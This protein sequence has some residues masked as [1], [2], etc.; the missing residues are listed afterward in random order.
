ME[1]GVLNRKPLLNRMVLV[2][3]IASL[4][5]LIG[6]EGRASA[7]SPGPRPAPTNPV[8]TIATIS[9]N[10]A[11]AGGAPFNLTI[12]GTNFVSSSAV[13]FG[14]TAPSTKFVSATQMTAAIPAD[15]ISSAGSI[16][17][18]VTS[19][20]PGGGTS[21]S[22]NFTVTSG[23]NP[24]PAISVLEPGG[25]LG[26]GPGLNLR[27]SGAN[28][29]ASSVVRWNGN[30]LPTTV[31]DS[32][33]A[34]AQIPASDV[35]ANGVASV[36]VVSPAP[37]GGS[38]SP[39]PF[40]IDG[41]ESPQSIAVDA[42]GKFVYVADGSGDV[43]EYSVDATT[44]ILTPIGRIAAGLSPR[45]IAIDPSGKFVYVADFGDNGDG[46]DV[47][48]ISM[49]SI[50]PSSGA[51]TSIGTIS[52]VPVGGGLLGCPDLCAPTSVDVDPSGKFLYVAN[53]GGPAPT[54]I[55]RWTVN[56]TGFLTF[57]G[58]FAGGGR[59]ISLAID[60]K[61]KF[62][63]AT[64]DS[65]SFPGE[66]NDVSMFTVN[67]TT[68]ALTFTGTIAAGTEPVSVAVDPSGKFVY[69]ANSASNDISVYTINVTTGAL[70]S[71]GT[72]AAGTRPISVAV[73]PTGKF[74]YVA[75]SDSNDISIYA[76]DGTTGALMSV[77]TVAT[78]LSPAAIAIHPSGKF[79]YVANSGSNSIS[80]Y[81][82]DATTGALTL[83]GTTG[84]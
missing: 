36:T 69:A 80:M 10:G 2:S 21:N 31:V 27:V 53:E 13:S 29:V 34:E 59:A 57:Q 25:A 70:T 50:S 79:V 26:G 61:G 5:L 78:E 43:S 7:P 49:Y 17:V 76:I 55:P 37:G 20:T 32:S 12:I 18:T 14:G 22:L 77:A 75:N 73:D 47:G 65:N 63:Y 82:I 4:A 40:T 58:T 8:P 54:L 56:S 71:A 83:I 84:T 11:Q 68:G 38:S 15:T 45:S 9:P 62:A 72:V 41:G 30:D 28:F 67:A 3:G 23:P 1:E 81:S 44:G 39:A 66:G 35:A 6:C 46:E 52:G 48:D 33:T 19:P 51:L 42:A 16:T 24:I 64:D 74:T 60:P